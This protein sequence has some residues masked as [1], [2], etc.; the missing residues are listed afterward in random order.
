MASAVRNTVALGIPLGDALRMASLTPAAF[1]RLDRELGR[2]APGYRASLVL[3][4]GGL[5]VHG[6]WIDG[7]AE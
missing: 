7:A 1:L 2:I 3:L 6:T 5:R 4:D